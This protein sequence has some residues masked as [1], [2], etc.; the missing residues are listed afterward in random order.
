MEVHARKIGSN[1]FVLVDVDDEQQRWYDKLKLG[2]IVAFT[3]RLT[4]S[5]KYHKRFFKLLEVAFDW[6]EAPDVEWRGQPVRKNKERFRK[7][8]LILAGYAYPVIDL[9]GGVH[10]EAESISFGNM[11]QAKFEEVYSAVLDVVLD[12][13]LGR[14][15]E[16][17]LKDAVEA[18]MSFA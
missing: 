3:A 5:Y 9:R 17:D 1:Q 15:R 8:C 6:W 12:K 7:D 16:K 11:D 14:V 18:L 4:R 13:V 10:M 2:A